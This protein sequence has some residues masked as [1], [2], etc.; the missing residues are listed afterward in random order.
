MK[1]RKINRGDIYYAYLNPVIGSEQGSCR[2][3]LVVQNDMG[4]EYSPT[5]II[6]PL[7]RNLRKS[8]LP[9]H[10][11]IPKYCGLDEDSLVLAEQIRTIDHS[12]LSN[13]IGYICKEIQAA[14]DEALAVCIGLEHYRPL[15]GEMLELTLCYH[16]ETDFRNSGYFVIKKGYRKILDNCDFCKTAKGLSFGIFSSDR[17]GR[18][19]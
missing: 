8:S 15:K 3:V 17:N 19:Y 5:V 13:Y 18:D 4:N 6:A 7:T 9:T 11:L 14:V 12:R 10:V 16:C 1:R 2:P